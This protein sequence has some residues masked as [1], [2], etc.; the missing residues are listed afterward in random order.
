MKENVAPGQRLM[1]TAGVRQIIIM[2]TEFSFFLFIFYFLFAA[3]SLLP[4]KMAH[5]LGQDLHVTRQT[6]SL[7]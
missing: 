6:L 1:A 3:N 5:I 7:N 4:S 2:S